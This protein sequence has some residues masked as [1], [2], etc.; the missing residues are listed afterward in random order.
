MR[1]VDFGG[2]ENEKRPNSINALFGL[3]LLKVEKR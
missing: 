1:E 3:C 2:M